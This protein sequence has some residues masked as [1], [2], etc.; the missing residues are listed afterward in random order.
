MAVVPPRSLL[1]FP[2]NGNGREALDCLAPSDRLLGFI[3]DAPEKEG[4]EVDG[5]P[6]FGRWALSSFQDASVLAVPGSPTSYRDRAEIIRG[7]DIP[8]ERFATV[9]HPTAAVSPRAEIG[10]NVLVMAGAVITANAIL[11][12]HVCVLPNTV[13]HHDAVVGAWSLIGSSVVLTG[14]VSVGENCYVGSGSSVMP[15]VRLGARSMIGLG[16]NVLCDVPPDAV[17]AGNP[18]RSLRG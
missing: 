6:V 16:S 7:L 1:I 14:G 3:D 9:V 17:V 10:R 13:V 2:C 8:K 18:A 15:G 11:G 4:T 12:D 5:F